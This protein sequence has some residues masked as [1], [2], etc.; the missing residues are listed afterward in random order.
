MTPK[1]IRI[2][3]P[4]INKNMLEWAY[5]SFFLT[6][7]SRNINEYIKQIKIVLSLYIANKFSFLLSYGNT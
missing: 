2:F 4:I 5:L 7:I 6:I 1:L 3:I